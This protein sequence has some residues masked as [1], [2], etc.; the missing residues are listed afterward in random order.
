MPR[1]YNQPGRQAWSTRGLERCRAA[2]GG[3]VI[4]G[5]NSF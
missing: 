4:F 2:A 3:A 5:K 1:N